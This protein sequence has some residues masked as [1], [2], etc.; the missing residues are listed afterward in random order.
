MPPAGVVFCVLLRPRPDADSHTVG[1]GDFGKA[2][3]VFFFV[4][5][6][7]PPNPASQ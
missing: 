1:W 6:A 7:A 5:A 2:R 3:V 4:F